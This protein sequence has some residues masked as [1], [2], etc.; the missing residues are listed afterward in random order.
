MKLDRNSKT[1]LK[2]SLRRE[3]MKIKDDNRG[4][5][6]VE[7]IVVVL[8]MA[9]IAIGV[10]AAIIK[11]VNN[12]RN[13]TDIQTVN[14]IRDNVALSLGNEEAFK[15][16]MNGGYEIHIIKDDTGTITYTYVGDVDG[17][18]RPVVTNPYWKFLLE[19]TGCEDYDDFEKRFT[20]KSEPPAGKT[21]SINVKVWENGF[22]YVTLDGIENEDLD[23][24]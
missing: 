17:A 7:L 21:I 12:S 9:I 10:S 16:V 6:L 5:S 15:E 11:W 4:F 23:L 19:T 8:I 2:V 1:Y 22:T 3:K 13:S 18:G 20:I 14:T 24:S